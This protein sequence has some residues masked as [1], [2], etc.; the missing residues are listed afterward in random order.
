[1]RANKNLETG[2][3]QFV[4]T[5]KGPRQAGPLIRSSFLTDDAEHRSDAVDHVE[6]AEVVDGR[7]HVALGRTR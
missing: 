4:I 7:L 2:Q 3:T 5:Y 1:M 6:V